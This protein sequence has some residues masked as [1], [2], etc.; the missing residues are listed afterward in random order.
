MN[1]SD[2][3][4]RLADLAV[5]PPDL[6]RAAL[7]ISYLTEA[8]TALVTTFA[9]PTDQGGL[10]AEAYGFASAALQ[11]EDVLSMLAG[12]LD[13]LVQPAVQGQ[14][15]KGSAPAPDG[16][17]SYFAA[18]I[19]P[20][21]ATGSITS[22]QY[23]TNLDTFFAAQ[24][25]VKSA[26]DLASTQVVANIKT[27][28]TR[29]YV[30]RA[31]LQ[32]LYADQFDSM[33]HLLGIKQIVPMGD[34]F[35]HTGQQNLEV[36]LVVSGA[37]S[38]GSMFDPNRFG[39]TIWVTYEPRDV[40][41]DCLICGVS[42]AVNRATKTSFQQNSLAEIFNK[43][44]AA[45]TDKALAAQL[46]PLP[47][48]LILPRNP[49]SQTTQPVATSYGY[50]QSLTAPPLTAQQRQQ[51][52]SLTA[53]VLIQP[54]AN[55][56]TIGSAF[57]LTM[58]A[59]CAVSST[60]SITGLS[61]SAI[62]A[63]AFVPHTPD[64]SAALIASVAGLED[65]GLFS[66]LPGQGG[67]DGSY[68]P[69]QVTTL[70]ANG[71]ELETQTVNLRT[72][73][74]LWTA[75]ATGNASVLGLPEMATFLVQGF[76]ASMTLWESIYTGADKSSVDAFVT[77]T[78]NVAV[79]V[80]AISP[81]LLATMY[82]EIFEDLPRA[83]SSLTLA[84]ACDT[85]VSSH[86]SAAATAYKTASD[87]NADPA[88]IAL[89]PLLA[90]KALQ[91]LQVPELYHQIGGQDVLGPDGTVIPVPASITLY[92]DPQHP[93]STTVL[94]VKGAAGFPNRAT[95]FADTPS[96]D[97]VITP[98]VKTLG[99]PAGTTRTNAL[100]TDLSKALGLGSDFAPAS[101]VTLG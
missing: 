89:S 38:A 41:I 98:Q 100:K 66:A 75:D 72:P 5:T 46:Q 53:N 80:P 63:S 78:A 71:S 79:A 92:L 30:D 16:Y 9:Q 28:C 62:V 99:T 12:L 68:Q 95:Y 56:T 20:T 2:I 82:Q 101:V 8:Q 14:M 87:T 86:L 42:E 6:L 4:A 58:G 64:T 17:D 26:L 96:S 10:G 57:Y 13:R 52:S 23:Q 83:G 47:V 54:D 24:P 1:Y 7:Y 74:R 15:A 45:N 48:Q 60:F 29:F 39:N 37:P 94:D 76:A 77:R 70:N 31:A 55:V 18:N 32:A 81:A 69:A 34:I 40:E 25:I 43:A 84:K 88:F 67:V 3:S 36:E 97:R 90:G 19:L 59:I 61:S 33:F 21:S 49:S 22:A 44:V 51:T 35:G 85:T 93:G 73:N 11:A 50:R 27:A 91:T 65:T